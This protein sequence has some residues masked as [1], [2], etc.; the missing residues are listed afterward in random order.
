MVVPTERPIYPNENYSVAQSTWAN[1][2]SK[3]LFRQASKNGPLSHAKRY[4]TEGVQN[5]KDG[6]SSEDRVQSSKAFN[7]FSYDD[8]TTDNSSIST[9]EARLENLKSTLA[10]LSNRLEKITAN[11]ASKTPKENFQVLNNAEFAPFDFVPSPKLLIRKNSKDVSTSVRK[12]KRRPSVEHKS[13]PEPKNSNPHFHKGELSNSIEPEEFFSTFL[14]SESS[15]FPEKDSSDEQNVLSE[16]KEYFATFLPRE[17]SFTTEMALYDEQKAVN[18]PKDFFAS[19]LLSDSSSTLEKNLRHDQRVIGHKDHKLEDGG[20]LVSLQGDPFTKTNF[21]IENHHDSWE[22]FT[23]TFD[24]NS[25]DDCVK[26]DAFANAETSSRFYTSAKDSHQP[27]PVQSLLSL[28]DTSQQRAKPE[29]PPLYLEE[30]LYSEAKRHDNRSGV[31]NANEFNTAVSSEKAI[32][33]TMPIISSRHESVTWVSQERFHAVSKDSDVY[34]EA[35]KT[36]KTFKTAHQLSRKENCKI[37]STED[38][39]TTLSDSNSILEHDQ[40]IRSF[41]EQRGDAPEESVED[42]IHEKNFQQ[43]DDIS[44]E[45]NHLE[46]LSVFLTAYRLDEKQ[47]GSIPEEGS[48]NREVNDEVDH[49]NYSKNPHATKE[50]YQRHETTTKYSDHCPQ[51]FSNEAMNFDDKVSD[52]SSETNIVHKTVDHAEAGRNGPNSSQEVC[53]PVEEANGNFRVSEPLQS[54]QFSNEE[55]YAAS[56]LRRQRV[57]H[58]KSISSINDDI[59]KDKYSESQLGPNECQQEVRNEYSHRQGRTH[60]DA[61]VRILDRP[62]LDL[63]DED[64]FDAIEVERQESND[65]SWFPESESRTVYSSNS[66]SY[67]MDPKPDPLPDPSPKGS[68]KLSPEGSRRLSYVNSDPNNAKE[69]P[70]GAT[71]EELKLLNH[72]I[73]VAS[74]NFGGNTL[75]AD[76]ESRVRAAA[77]KVGLTEKFVDQLLNQTIKRENPSSRLSFEPSEQPP[78]AY[79]KGSTKND[80]NMHL[81][82]DGPNYAANQYGGE[83]ATNDDIDYSQRRRGRER[84]RHGSTPEDCS[85]WDSLG[86]TFG[87]LANMTARA[88]GMEYHTSRRDDASSVVSAISWEDDNAGPKV[89]RQKRERQSLDTTEAYA[90]GYLA[91]DRHDNDND[92]DNDNTQH[93]TFASDVE[94]EGETKG[95]EGSMLPNDLATPP[96]PKITQLV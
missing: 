40:G 15:S 86:K 96:R 51:K 84:R 43:S 92:N 53:W 59:T 22:T 79:K 13:R 88:C 52:A 65:D 83:D 63:D 10:G 44:E 47:R 48:G 36:K 56:Q 75:S 31:G 68:R 64:C 72:F 67:Q 27:D 94:V 17:T 95:Q 80:Y 54:D 69:A 9:S 58:R 70:E 87:L 20:H 32:Y 76:S 35:G 90:P 77:L 73:D 3:N 28:N 26:N 12:I 21:Q 37:L 7:H 45:R 71:E 38:Q 16:P 49:Q 93:V 61:A 50:N 57:E 55:E 24:S 62:L 1:F 66:R 74:S 33:P 82:H 41:L 39:C 30:R 42:D 4:D 46:A 14:A 89:R 2:E 85:A 34:V 18:E 25:R 91:A 11:S 8:S 19:I 60:R 29:Y 23:S 6:E 5:A 78:P 81:K